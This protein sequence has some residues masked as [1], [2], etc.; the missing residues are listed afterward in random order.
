MLD[1]LLVGLQNLGVAPRGD[2]HVRQIVPVGRGGELGFGSRTI[3]RSVLD[4]IGHC[5]VSQLF[6]LGS[7]LLLGRQ[8][9]DRVTD[10]ILDPIGEL[11]RAVG[12]R[13]RLDAFVEGV[14]FAIC[15]QRA[16]LESHEVYLSGRLTRYGNIYNPIR[17]CL[18]ELG[19][20]VSPL[21]TLSTKSKA[22]AQG[23]AIV[24]NGLYGGYYEP[25]VKHM[26]I[27]KAEGSV[28]DYVYWR[29]RI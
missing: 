20:A 15:S 18:E 12:G 3:G 4:Q 14:K 6:P 17:V 5:L 13:Q 22:A 23:Y 26:M 2:L 29:D 10:V 21:P 1:N 19:Y 27:D 9:A 28:V 24:G 8:L 7:A 25:L 11:F 16:L